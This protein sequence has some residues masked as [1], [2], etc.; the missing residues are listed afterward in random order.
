MNYR[1]SYYF[2]F[3]VFMGIGFMIICGFIIGLGFLNSIA[4]TI[5]GME[6]NNPSLVVEFNQTKAIEDF[7]RLY[8]DKIR[9]G[10]ED[11]DYSD[12]KYSGQYNSSNDPYWGVRR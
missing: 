11:N 9:A 1:D 6:I 5:S 8:G 12:L 4:N 7:D 3:G 2:A 10:L